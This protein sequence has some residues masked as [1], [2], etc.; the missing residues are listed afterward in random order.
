MGMPLEEDVPNWAIQAMTYLATW[1]NGKDIGRSIIL[2]GKFSWVDSLT[3]SG[4]KTVFPPFYFIKQSI[5]RRSGEK[6]DLEHNYQT[7]FTIFSRFL[8]KFLIQ[9][10]VNRKSS[11]IFFIIKSRVVSRA[12]LFGSGSGR[13]RA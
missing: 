3:I 12:G 13:V 8:P 6:C 4:P 11:R 7:L 1:L 9:S 10:K 2:R 5:Q